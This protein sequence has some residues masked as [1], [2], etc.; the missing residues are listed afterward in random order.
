VVYRTGNGQRLFAFFGTALAGDST[1]GLVAATNRPQEIIVYEAPSG[2]IVMH[3]DLDHYPL[4]AR[5]LPATRE[6]LVLSA[7]QHVYRLAV[8][9][10]PPP[11]V[12][13]AAR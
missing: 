1:M 9:S 7:T 10:P 5:F 11:P 2:K 4:A 6:L 3:V 8:P 12:E 13:Q